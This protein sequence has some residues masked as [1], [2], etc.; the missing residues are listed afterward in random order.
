MELLTYYEMGSCHAAQTKHSRLQLTTFLINENRN[1]VYVSRSQL[2]N[3]S[4]LHQISIK[5]PVVTACDVYSYKSHTRLD[6]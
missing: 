3:K 2:I 1:C 6:V 4:G 5:M